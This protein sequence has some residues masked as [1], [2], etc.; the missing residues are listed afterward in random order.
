M[1]IAMAEMKNVVDRI[2]SRQALQKKKISELEDIAIEA[3]KMKHKKKI[4]S[5]NI[6]G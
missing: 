1:K 4:E 3:S 5:I 2:N 6:Q